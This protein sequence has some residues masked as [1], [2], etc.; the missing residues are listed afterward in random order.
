MIL[1]QSKKV[2]ILCLAF[3]ICCSLDAP[4]EAQVCGNKF[5]NGTDEF[6]YDNNVYKR[7]GKWSN[8]YDPRT[9]KC[10][11]GIVVKICGNNYYNENQSFCYENEVYE[12]CGWNRYDPKTQK[13]LKNVAL[14]ECGETYFSIDT[15]NIVVTK[16]GD[17]YYNEIK[18]FCY[19]KEI[20]PKCNRAIYDLEKQKCLENT[21][22][23]HCKGEIYDPYTHYCKSQVMEKQ[24]FTDL[25]DNKEYKIIEIGE[26]IWMAENLNYSGNDNE[27]GKCYRGRAPYPDYEVIELCD[28]YGRLYDWETAMKVCPDGWHLP[29]HEE[30]EKLGNEVGENA[31]KKLKSIDGWQCIG[32]IMYEGMP[33]SE[34]MD[35]WGDLEYTSGY[36]GACQQPGNGTDEFGFSALAS[37]A[38]SH[39]GSSGYAIEDG[40]WWSATDEGDF[41]W[42]YSEEDN[43]SAYINMYYASNGLKFSGA[44][45]LHFLSVRCVRD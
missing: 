28:K 6:C 32:N 38:I 42:R 29:S 34:F 36:Q 18:E 24:V 20:Q 13:C 30:W 4:D 27:L 16:C 23:N 25:R 33:T 12:R 39:K 35:E 5:Y 41:W 43:K 10:E 45:K 11:D 26:Q 8:S 40:F 37:G 3:L 19:K 44:Y 31:G 1:K 22:F 21:L 17:D 9:E 15:C 2:L 14:E 7:C